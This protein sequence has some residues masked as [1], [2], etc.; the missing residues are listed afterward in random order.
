MNQLQSDK[1]K[2][3]LISLLDCYFNHKCAGMLEIALKADTFLTEI[4]EPPIT[5]KPVIKKVSELPLGTRFKVPAWSKTQVYVLLEKWGDGK[6]AKYTTH[7]GPVAGQSIVS[8]VENEGDLKGFE[9][10]VVS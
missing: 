8:I 5:T 4:G 2:S 9:V 6:A 3:Y 7:D 10:E 1:L